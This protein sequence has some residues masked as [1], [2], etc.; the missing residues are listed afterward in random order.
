MGRRLVLLLLILIF[1]VMFL[2]IP[3]LFVYLTE[4]L[5]F[6]WVGFLIVFVWDLGM[7]FVFA[8]EIV[9]FFDKKLLQLAAKENSQ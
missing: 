4:T 9:P 8:R 5:K 3:W 1:V 2:I 6:W 7:F